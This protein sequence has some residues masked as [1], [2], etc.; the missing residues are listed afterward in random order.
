MNPLGI[1]LI[2][3]G[4]VAAVVWIFIIR[5]HTKEDIKDAANAAVKSRL[6]LED[7][8]VVSEKFAVLIRDA[9]AGLSAERR[10]AAEVASG[11]QAVRDGIKKAQMDIRDNTMA[12]RNLGAQMKALDSP[13]MLRA[14]SNLTRAERTLATLTDELPIHEKAM[15]TAQ[16]RVRIWEAKIMDYE[17]GRDTLLEQIESQQRRMKVQGLVGETNIRIENAE[18]AIA[19]LKKKQEKNEQIL[20]GHAIVMEES[21]DSKNRR[22]D[23][24]IGQANA[25]ARAAE[26]LGLQNNN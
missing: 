19:R 20:R 24:S 25:M 21:M 26:I 5:P 13:E 15:E 8:R 14:S 17:E 10:T 22:A 16:E 2:A 9:K 12:I 6:K 7:P 3:L 18:E 1:I 23:E 11:L 4:L